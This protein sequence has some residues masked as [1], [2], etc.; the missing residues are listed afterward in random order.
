[1]A[2]RHQHTTAAGEAAASPTS[3]SASSPGIS[4]SNYNFGGDDGVRID[5]RCLPSTIPG[6]TREELAA[7]IVQYHS[8][9][10]K[11]AKEMSDKALAHDV[12][13]MRRSLSPSSFAEYMARL[14][15]EQQAAVKEEAKM[16]AMS[17]LEL[18]QYRQKKRRQAIRYEWYKTFLVL[19]AIAGSIA[20]LFSLFIFFK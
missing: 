14:E 15:K 12:E 18:H 17:P 16:A 10:S 11:L 20:F 13:L 2:V 6:I 9:Q 5:P 4:S 3:A 8:Q 7:R 1:M 19:V